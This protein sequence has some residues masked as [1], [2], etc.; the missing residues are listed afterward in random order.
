M[1]SPRASTPIERRRADL[2]RLTAER[3]DVLVVG[4]GVTGAGTA[5]DAASRGLSVALLERSD[6]AAGTSSRSSRLIH[7]GLRYLEQFRFGLVREALAER[8]RLLRLAPHLVRLEPLLFPLY[9]SVLARPFYGSG[10]TLY[11]L[12]GAARDGGR[13]RHLGRADAVAS[14]PALRRTGLRGAFVFHDGVEDDARF[15]LAVARTAQ[16]HGALVLTRARVAGAIRDGGRV[17]GARARDEEGGADLEVRA[18]AVIDAT[19]V[20]SGQPDGAFPGQP[21]TDR[22]GGGMARD[23][24]RRAA[25]NTAHVIRPSRGTHLIVRR[26]RIPSATGLTIRAPGKVVFL[27]PWPGHW[28]I[29]TTDVPYDG[30]PDGVVPTSDDVDEI[31]AA[32]NRTLDIDLT[33]GDVVGAYAGLRPL[34]ADGSVSDGFSGNESTLRV[35]REHRVRI[36]A[37]GLARIGGGKYTTYRVMAADVVDAALD[38]GFGRGTARA[39]PSRTAELPLVGA[40]SPA[41][42]DRLAAAIAATLEAR[43][44]ER[45]HADR[46]VARHGSQ[47]ADVVA[48]GEQLDL[49]RPISVEAGEQSEH[50]EAEVVWAAREE[51][52]VGLDDVLV[53]RTRLAQ[54]MT[55]R[56]AAVAPRVAALLG[57][58]LGWDAARQA[59]EVA[60]FLDRAHR[61]FDVPPAS[62]SPPSSVSS[63]GSRS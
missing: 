4:G 45:R 36:E 46:L 22:D 29:G 6:I 57:Q 40:E 48:L 33:R 25:R 53:R 59:N 19:G 14:T 41:E 23:T 52:A 28:L 10:L 30:V 3:W 1:T 5:L 60:R 2:Q 34:V 7:G 56:A 35:S 8:S 20:W 39:R 51:L 11:D 9:G 49:L 13:H 18:R 62:P 44:L 61:E 37:D 27:V 42:L 16:A 32:A 55:D 17:T 24:V 15:A 47:A 54:E 50:L 58:E 38:A 12:L 31:L 21:P 43:G 63:S 26:E